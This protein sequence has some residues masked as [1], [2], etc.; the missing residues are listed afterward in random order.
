MSKSVGN[1]V[2]PHDIIKKYGADMLR[3]WVASVDFTEDVRMS[4]T[5]LQRMSDAYRKL[6]NTFRYALG[7]LDDF[8]P[9]SDSVLAAEMVEIDLW[10]LARAE[11]LIG[12]CR[13]WYDDYDFHK[14]YRAIYDFATTDLSAVYFDILKDRLYTAAVQSP[15][16]RSAQTA[17]YRLTYALVRL[18]APLLSFTT[19]EVWGHLRKPAGAPE[20]VH[21]ALLPEPDEVTEGFTTEQRRRIENWDKLLPVRDEVLKSLDTARKEKLIGAPL[22]AR[23]RLTADAELHPLLEEYAADLPTLFI[24]S[25]VALENGAAD[26]LQVAIERADGQKCERCWKYKPEVGSYSDFPTICGDCKIALTSRQP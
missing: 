10:I 12:K 20:S 21:L 13:A 23:V 22:E 3:L 17:L 2:D 26:G 15:A 4:D 19:E 6:R 14:T 9:A 25:Q 5:I 16:R 1:V 24:V 18:L 8:D 7:N 11:E